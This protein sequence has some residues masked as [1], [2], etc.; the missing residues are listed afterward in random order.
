VP[1]SFTVALATGM[2]GS[3]CETEKSP[4]QVHYINAAGKEVIQLATKEVVSTQCKGTV[5]KPTAEPG[6]LCIYTAEVTRVLIT[7]ESIGPPAA[8]P[9]TSIGTGT[10]GAVLNV[11]V[12]EASSEAGGKGTWA[13]TAE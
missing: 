12:E 5:E 13:V 10:V 1:I 7:T 3:G 9:F 6:N 2:N 4:C 11:D 8:S